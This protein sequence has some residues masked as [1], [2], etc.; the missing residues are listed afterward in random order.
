M[1]GSDVIVDDLRLKREARDIGHR[2]RLAAGAAGSEELRR[3]R[4]AVG[5]RRTFVV[6]GPMRWATLVGH[7]QVVLS[8]VAL[9]NRRVFLFRGHG[10]FTVPWPYGIVRKWDELSMKHVRHRAMCQGIP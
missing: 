3:F 5:E 4:F 9:D 8:F 1:D 10:A 6:S 2:E 7:G